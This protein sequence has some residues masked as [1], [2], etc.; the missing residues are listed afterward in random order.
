MNVKRIDFV[1]KNKYKL[2]P[3]TMPSITSAIN[4]IQYK[5]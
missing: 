4:Y 3:L 1:K 2:L 5:K